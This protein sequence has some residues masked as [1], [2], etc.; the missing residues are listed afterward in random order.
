MSWKRCWASAGR[1]RIRGDPLAAAATRWPLCRSMPRRNSCSA[2]ARGWASALPPHPT[3]PCPRPTISRAMG[4]RPACTNRGF[5]P[6]GLLGRCEGKRGCHLYPHGAG[7][8][9]AEVRS[10]CFVTQIERD[11]NGQVVGVVY[12]SMLAV[13]I[14]SVAGIFFCVRGRDRDAAPIAHEWV[15]QRQ[16]P[17]RTEFHGAHRPATLGSLRQRK[18]GPSKASPAA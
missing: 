15:S 12:T 8:A 14:A 9:G 3:P 13:N 1:A 6:S 7:R 16:R 17:G 18:R 4:W 11:A 10:E 2:P 5:L